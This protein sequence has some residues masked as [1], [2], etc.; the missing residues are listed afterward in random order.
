MHNH[1]RTIEFGDSL[2]TIGDYAFAWPKYKIGLH[3]LSSIQSIGKNAFKDNVILNPENIKANIVSIDIELARL[4][5]VFGIPEI[6]DDYSA[7]NTIGFS[8]GTVVS[9]IFP[10]NNPYNSFTFVFN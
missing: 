6:Y 3:I 9:T 5:I 10:T 8:D 2:S 7:I 4:S 1:F